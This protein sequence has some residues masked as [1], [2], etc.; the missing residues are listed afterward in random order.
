MEKP[1]RM[2]TQPPIDPLQT[3]PPPTELEK[4]AQDFGRA[5]VVYLAW[6]A[7]GLLDP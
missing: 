3:Q 5:L 2:D 7:T 1:Q 4:V 6:K